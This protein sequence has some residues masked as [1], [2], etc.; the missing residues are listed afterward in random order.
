MTDFDAYL[1]HLNI[2]FI[3]KRELL[4]S[5]SVI[6]LGP[7]VERLLCYCHTFMMMWGFVF[8]ASCSKHVEEEA[9]NAAHTTGLHEGNPHLAADTVGIP[10]AMQRTLSHV[11]LTPRPWPSWPQQQ[12]RASL[13]LPQVVVLHIQLQ[14]QGQP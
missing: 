4:I 5:Y 10:Q 1:P 6:N 7:M 8:I 12:D 11:G 2:H 14:Q 9:F 13:T 3:T